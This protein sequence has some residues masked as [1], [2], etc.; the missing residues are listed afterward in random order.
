MARRA[1]VVILGCAAGCGGGGGPGTPDAATGPTS[2]P[3][4]AGAS[5]AAQ[6][7]NDEQNQV[8]LAMGVGCA[9]VVNTITTA[10]D[11]HT[12]YYTA[13]A[14][15]AACVGNAHVEVSTCPMFY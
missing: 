6:T 1:L 12:A 3:P 9:T 5:A 11:K 15:N 7:A 4:T 2:C 8:R 13:N 10:S 14:G